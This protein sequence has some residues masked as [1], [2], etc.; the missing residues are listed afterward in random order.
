LPTQS[1]SR[2]GVWDGI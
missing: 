1:V 2:D